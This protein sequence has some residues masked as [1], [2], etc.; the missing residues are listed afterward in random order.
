[1]NTRES[2]ATAPIPVLLAITLWCVAASHLPGSVAQPGR[3]SAQTRVQIRMKHQN[4][5]RML[6]HNDAPYFID[7]V[8]P[9]APVPPTSTDASCSDVFG[10]NY[11][12]NWRNSNFSLCDPLTDASRLGKL[13]SGIQ[14]FNNPRKAE[15]T[16]CISRR[17][18]AAPF[19]PAHACLHLAQGRACRTPPARQRAAAPLT[20]PDWV[21]AGTWWWTPRRSWARPSRCHTR[22]TATAPSR[23][24]A[25][26]AR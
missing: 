14:C 13:I 26:L 15:N 19:G 1:M 18:A 23:R 22:R 17:V 4:S 10:P 20:S 11:L 8:H 24:K 5:H 6:H 16:F 2:H 7:R 3:D 12:I 21:P 9:E 25:R